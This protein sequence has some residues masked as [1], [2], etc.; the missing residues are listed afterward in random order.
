LDYRSSIR[1]APE[2]I[3][4][5]SRRPKKGGSMERDELRIPIPSLRGGG[6]SLEALCYLP[7]KA[8]KGKKVD[9]LLPREVEV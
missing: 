8:I 7:R 4:A 9:R 3:F 5:L 6:G 1:R 2:L